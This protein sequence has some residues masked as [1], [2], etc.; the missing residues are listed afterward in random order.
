VRKGAHG[1]GPGSLP[2]ADLHNTI[3]VEPSV[4]AT[5]ESAILVEKGGWEYPNKKEEC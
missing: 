1:N 3:D 5:T 4:S 2:M